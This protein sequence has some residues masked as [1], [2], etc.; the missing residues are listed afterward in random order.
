MIDIIEKKDCT[1]CKMCAD[2]CPRNAI[3]FECDKMGFW[4]PKVDNK[5]CIKCNI[6]KHACP[7]LNGH[8][9]RVKDKPDVYAMWSKSDEVRLS[10][11]SG[12]VFYEIGKLF[13]EDGGAVVGSKYTDDHKAAVH[14]IAK[15]IDELN[16]IKGSKYFQSDTEGIYKETKLE[17]EKGTKVLF[18]GTPCQVA[19]LN[20][21]LKKEYENLF[22]LDFICRS[23]NSPLAFKKYLEELESINNSK[24]VDVR[25]KDKTTGWRSLA[26]KITFENGYVFHR[27][28]KNDFWV[29]GFIEN[30]LYTRDSCFNCKY[31]SIPRLNADITVGDFWGIVGESE[32][33]MF[34]GISVALVNS[35][36]G[37]RILNELKDV[38]EI[39]HHSLNH[40]LPGNPALLQSPLDVGAKRME[41]FNYLNNHTF[42]EAVKKYIPNKK[43]GIVYRVLAKVYRFCRNYFAV[44][45]RPE[46]SSCKWLYYNYFCKHIIRKGTG[47]VLPY[48]NVIINFDKGSK[49]IIDGEKD[50]ILGYNKLVGSRAETHIRMDK[51]SRWY[52]NHGCLLFYNSV[53]EVKEDAV[54]TTGFFS[55]NGG[56]VIIVD[57]EMK[58]GEDVMIG[59]NVTIYDSDFH[60]ILDDS[61]NMTNYPKPVV[62]E[63][64]V[65]LTSNITVLKG[66]TI[67]ADSLITASTVVAKDVPSNVIVGGKSIGS[68]IKNDINWSRDRIKK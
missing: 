1:G 68:V 45:R 44:L 2:I 63:D 24:I 31:R 13:V 27:D 16:A 29:K 7:S 38:V 11:T 35:D 25:L 47:K 53:I 42:S 37:M 61:G 36:K 32:E 6:C 10:S 34:K 4:Y 43:R 30:D 23:I 14:Y 21:Y 60:Q 41:F 15:T 17:L 3:K 66:V 12:G 20:A 56:S 57:K 50:L 48:K 28:R 51:N 67:G 64:H 55:A 65:W 9:N 5:L 19:S 33:N 59:R 39:E 54:L 22:V 40:V 58:F 62:I 26:S 8:L 46:L 52:A 49:I 18:C